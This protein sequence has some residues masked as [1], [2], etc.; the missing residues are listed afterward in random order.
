ML[1]LADMGIAAGDA[2]QRAL[3]ARLRQPWRWQW[4]HSQHAHIA[5]G[6]T[7]QLDLIVRL[8]QPWQWLRVRYAEDGVAA[9]DASRLTLIAHL[10][11]PWRW[12]RLWVE[13]DE[14]GVAAGAASQLALR[15]SRLRKQLFTQD[16]EGA[17]QRDGA[18]GGDSPARD[19]RALR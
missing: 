16:L 10:R 5:A 9:G 18:E 12:Q 4:P 11:H 14:A 7:A 15:Q 1:R 8:R 2:V 19:H 13:H 6:D 3:I 17:G